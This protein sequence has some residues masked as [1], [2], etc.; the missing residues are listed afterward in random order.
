MSPV[1]FN[2]LRKNPKYYNYLLSSNREKDKLRLPILE[3]YILRR[4][5]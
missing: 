5:K 4:K 1:A 2:E 3:E